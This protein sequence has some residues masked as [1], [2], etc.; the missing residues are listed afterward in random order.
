[1]NS[2]SMEFVQADGGYKVSGQWKYCSGSTHATLFT[3][4]CVLEEASGTEDL[5][6]GE[7][8]SAQVIRSLIFLPEQV[9]IVKDWNAFGMKATAS[10]SIAVE[11]DPAAESLAV[12]TR[13]H[14]KL[15]IRTVSSSQC[16]RSNK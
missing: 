3:A 11:D 13:K 12:R 5:S 16:G 15:R 2:L 6:S 7:L 9:R 1:M 10:Y 4:N 8:S 14:G